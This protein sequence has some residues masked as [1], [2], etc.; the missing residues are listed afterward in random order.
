MTNTA[1][2]PTY[3]MKR[4]NWGYVIVKH[5][6]EY[7]RPKYLKHVI[8]GQYVWYRD[9][10]WGKGFCYETAKKHLNALNAGAELK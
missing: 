9:M 5:D 10:I 3:E 8:K 6:P 7:P 4:L 2:R 1:E